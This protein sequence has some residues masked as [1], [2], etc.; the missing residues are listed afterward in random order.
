MQQNVIRKHK[1]C[2]AR[3]IMWALPNMWIANYAQH[4]VC[5]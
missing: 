1:L 2:A 4:H 3:L 5:T